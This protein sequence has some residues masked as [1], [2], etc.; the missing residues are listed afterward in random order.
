[1]RSHL[2]PLDRI[3]RRSDSLGRLARQ[4]RDQQALLERVRASLPEPL[5]RHCAAAVLHGGRLLLFAD[6]PAW[7]SRIRFMTPR[8]LQAVNTRSTPARTIKVRILPQ[9]EA[10]Q[11][12][13]RPPARLPAAE[14]RL[15]GRVA[16]QTADPDLRAALRRLA[17]CAFPD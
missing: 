8:I 7:G 16:E 11:P 6:S 3:M 4:A 17:A 1:M 14:A 2:R 13:T 9:T 10:S 5:G 12:R 15:I